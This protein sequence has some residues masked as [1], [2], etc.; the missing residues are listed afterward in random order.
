MSLPQISPLQC[1]FRKCRRCKA[2]FAYAA[3]QTAAQNGIAAADIPGRQS[4][5]MFASSSS[6]RR[7]IAPLPCSFSVY[8]KLTDTSA[9]PCAMSND[10]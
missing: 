5:R 8:Q 9:L 3:L 2:A 7:R 1:C 10:V 4:N 6:I